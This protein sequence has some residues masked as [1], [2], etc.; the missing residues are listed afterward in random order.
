LDYKKLSELT[1]GYV[2]ADLEAICDE[3]ARDASKDILELASKLD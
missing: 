1:E 2:A 3:V